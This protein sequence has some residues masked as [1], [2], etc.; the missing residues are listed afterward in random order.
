LDIALAGFQ[1]IPV[2]ARFGLDRRINMKELTIIILNEL[3]KE[4]T[5][6]AIKVLVKKAFESLSNKKEKEGR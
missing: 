3:A 5:R 1:R 2:S 6:Q 4:V